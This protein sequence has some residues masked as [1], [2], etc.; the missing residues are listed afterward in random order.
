MLAIYAAFIAIG[1]M[2]DAQWPM[3]VGFVAVVAVFVAPHYIKFYREFSSQRCLGC[4]NPAG[5]IVT[6]QGR[7]HLVCKHCQAV[8]PTD[9]A[10][11]WNVPTKIE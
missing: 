3:V 7:I 6:R 10:M 2:M 5:G 8:T 4:G 1:V 11:W 9:C